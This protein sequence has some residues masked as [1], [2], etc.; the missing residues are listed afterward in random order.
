M[1]QKG[2]AQ[3]ILVMG[4]FGN[5]GS[6]QSLRQKRKLR[7]RTEKRIGDSQVC[8]APQKVLKKR[9]QCHNYGGLHVEAPNSRIPFQ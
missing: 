5:L 7:R 2:G 1:M 6:S 8:C 4:F 3:A 9:P